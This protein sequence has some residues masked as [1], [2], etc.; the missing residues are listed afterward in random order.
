MT[1]KSIFNDMTP[2]ELIVLAT[3]VRHYPHAVSRYFLDFDWNAGRLCDERLVDDLGGVLVA[4][5]RGKAFIASVLA[6]PLPEV[7]QCPTR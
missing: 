3:C 5:D 1:V 7:P 2:G 4:T 6:L